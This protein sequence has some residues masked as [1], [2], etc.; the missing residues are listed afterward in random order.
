MTP[1]DPIFTALIS[2]GTS[3]LT[4]IIAFVVKDSYETQVKISRTMLALCVD[5][6]GTIRAFE[7]HTGGL[8]KGIKLL[9]APNRT[10]DDDFNILRTLPFGFIVSPP[11]ALPKELVNLLPAEHSRFVFYYHDGWERF[12]VLESRYRD[13]FQL[14]L[15]DVTAAKFDS[16]AKSR[17]DHLQS[18]RY[19]QL[20]ALAE[21][22]NTTISRL[23]A[24][25]CE[26]LLL[27]PTYLDHNSIDSV[28]KLTDGRWNSWQSIR[29]SCAK[30]HSEY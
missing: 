13:L 5:C 16:S 17:Y 22:L 10:L 24:H 9:A 2:V 19:E 14:L 8:R 15:T 28:T 26:I 21:D 3:L 23:L 11:L 12:A 6:A 18:E 27:A 1:P 7:G 25:S 20:K 4:T 29:E 30:F